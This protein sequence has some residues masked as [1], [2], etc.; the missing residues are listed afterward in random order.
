MRISGAL[1]HCSVP[2]HVRMWYLLTFGKG[3]QGMVLPRTW[4]HLHSL[5]RIIHP[6]NRIMPYT[7]YLKKT[8]AA[9]VYEITSETPLDFAPQIS[10]RI[11]NQVYLKRE[12]MHAV[13]SYKIRGAYNKMAQLT[14]AQL[15][16]G[17]ITAS[18][19]N[20]AQ[21]VAYS[22]AKLKCKA[23]IVVPETTPV[24]KVDAIKRFGGEYAEVVLHGTSYTDAYEH[25]VHLEKER[26]LTFVHPFDDPDV[27]AGQG[28]IGMEILRQYDSSEGPLDAV[29]VSIGGGGA[30]T[31]IASYIKSIRPE[32]KII[33]V[34]TFD[35]DAMKRSIDEGKRVTLKEVGIFA[36]GTAVKQVGKETFRLAKDLVDEIILVDT[37]AI[38]AAIK[39]VFQDTRSI[40]EPSGALALAGL[41]A[42]VEQHQLKGKNLIA[43][44]SGANTNFDRLRFVADRVEV[45]QARE[46]LFAVTI[47]EE[48]GSFL[49]LCELVGQERSVTEFNYRMNETKAAH[50]MVG[51]AVNNAQE[52]IK[53]AE[54]FS[55]KGFNTLDLTHNELAKQHVRNMIGGASAS[56]TDELIYRFEF[57]ERPGVLMHFLSEVSPHWN[58]SLFQYRN[59]GGDF[60]R[61]LVGIQ[62][63]VKERA[64]FKKFVTGLG[65][66]HWDETDNLVY[67]LFLKA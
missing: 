51:I 11:H 7:N 1:V 58:I 66:R 13:F 34:Q 29:F 54:K 3:S 50:I 31:G 4:P 30:I 12:D 18:A 28:T 14:P 61:I 41:K 21:G 43:V 32:V 44:A 22:A 10:R 17:V 53:I 23:V 45:G 20:H 25:A 35:S 37:D 15:K 39:D 19:G 48:R 46:A 62:V 56:I 8:L 36:D 26:K 55:K 59:M 57:P 49:R 38:C 27:I 2:N 40:L 33:G 60:G 52:S 6:P 24:I 64:Q 9:R 63:P 5:P 67:Q 47:P 65:Y 16:Q 42:Y